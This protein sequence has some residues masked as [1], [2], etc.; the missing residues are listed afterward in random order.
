MSYAIINDSLYVSYPV[1]FEELEEETN[2]YVAD[3]MPRWG[4]ND[5]KHHVLF[6]IFCM[7]SNSFMV[8][9]SEEKTALKQIRKVAKKSRGF[10]DLGDNKKKI[11]GKEVNGFRYQ[12]TM[13]DIVQ[14]CET[15][16]IKNNRCIYVIYCYVR[17]T[18][19][20][21]LKVVSELYDS[22]EFLTD[23]RRKEIEAENEQKNINV[24]NI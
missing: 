21:E 19:D 20:F 2:K 17:K 8:S 3:Q 10:K 14:Y 15:Y 13:N 5:K 16:T 1:V 12:Y 11:C 22:M 4:I 18:E 9:L 7:P 24:N 23:E 6:S